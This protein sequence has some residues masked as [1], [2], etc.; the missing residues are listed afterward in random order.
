[1]ITYEDYYEDLLLLF[2]IMGV[3]VGAAMTALGI[4]TPSDSSFYWEF[5]LPLGLPLWIFSTVYIT[6]GLT[7][8]FRH[9][10]KEALTD[11]SR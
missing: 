3:W 11:Y 1:M 10:I 6:K 8:E 9:D 7:F 2:T 4:F 5:W